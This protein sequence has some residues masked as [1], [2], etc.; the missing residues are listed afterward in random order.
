[1]CDGV[2]PIGIEKRRCRGA[3]SQAHR[4]A[5]CPGTSL[6]LLLEPAIGQVKYP[7][8]FRHCFIFS[9]VVFLE[10]LEDGLLH[11]RHHV[12]VE[13]PVQEANLQRFERIVGQPADRAAMLEHQVFDDDG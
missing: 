1:M 2:N 13:E 8:G 10:S 3:V 5:G 7:P 12:V 9:G 11:R 6:E 4:L